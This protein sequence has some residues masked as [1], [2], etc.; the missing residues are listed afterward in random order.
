MFDG[1]TIQL[2]IDCDIVVEARCPCQN[3]QDIN[4]AALGWDRTP[5][6]CTAISLPGC[7]V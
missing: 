1:W 5:P 2:L 7:D 4:L 3:V 6:Q